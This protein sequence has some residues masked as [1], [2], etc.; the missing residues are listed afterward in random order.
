MPFSRPP[1]PALRPFV[2]LLWASDG[3]ELSGSGAKRELVLPT[4]S[5]HI[6]V[7]LSGPPLRL[8]RDKDDRVGRSLAGSVIGGARAG[9][10]L[11]EVSA[12]RPSIGALLR[13]GAAEL[14][15]GAPAG[16]FSY[17]HTL[18]ED[19]WGAGPVAALREQ[20]D[21]ATS[22][23]ERLSL[24]EAAL[25][26]RLPELHSINPLVVHALARF[27][28]CWS[29]GAIVRD[30]GCSHRHFSRTFREAVGLGPKTY[31]RVLRFGRALRRLSTDPEI[32]WAELALSAGYAD[33]SHFNREFL[34]LSG[35]TPGHYH[36]IAPA[37]LRH[38][39]LAN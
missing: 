6:I 5:L 32:G 16:L 2:E 26:A 38:V 34:E 21:A 29:V 31:T 23:S 20:L 15:I 30:V 3:R 24:F 35:L 1:R 33:Q 25:A 11:K 18:L 19:V 27:E 17:R 7:V 37:A 12:P 28:A 10:Y 39:P 8:F 22:P 36:R 9:P 14:M 13:P 4:G